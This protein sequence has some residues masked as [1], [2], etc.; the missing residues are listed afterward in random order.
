M[1]SQRPSHT[2]KVD[3]VTL[4]N[5]LFIAIVLFLHHVNY[6]QDYLWIMS[7]RF[8][9]LYKSG[10]SQILQKLAVGGFSL[11]SGYK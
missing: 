11:L 4:M 5:L 2:K 6:T 1:K 3:N 9:N 7:H 8:I 10:I